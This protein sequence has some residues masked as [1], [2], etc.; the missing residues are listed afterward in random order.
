MT[1]TEQYQKLFEEQVNFFAR[2]YDESNTPQLIIEVKQKNWYG[3]EYF[4]S[5]SFVRRVSGLISNELVSV[6][7]MSGPTGKLFY[8]DYNYS[9]KINSDERNEYDSNVRYMLGVDPALINNTDKPSWRDT[10][11]T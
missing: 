8:L 4:S 5:I 1:V 7:P 3:E 6:Q 9:D 2:Y 10:I 11:I